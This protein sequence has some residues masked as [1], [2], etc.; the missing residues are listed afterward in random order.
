[1][2][3]QKISRTPISKRRR[4]KRKE[5]YLDPSSPSSRKL[6]RVRRHEHWREVECWPRV[7][8][9]GSRTENILDAAVSMNSKARADTISEKQT[10]T[11]LVPSLDGSSD[12]VEI[13]LF[14]LVQCEYELSVLGRRL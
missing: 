7:F 1:L 9:L 11:N 5:S 8:L 2:A 13:V 6:A 3:G 12:V 14:H 10:R 4:V